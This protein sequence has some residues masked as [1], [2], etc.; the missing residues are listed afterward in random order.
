MMQLESPQREERGLKAFDQHCDR[1][2]R[3]R[4]VCVTKADPLGT[5]IAQCKL[6]I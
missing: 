1:G 5:V 6:S 2:F 4:K 3:V